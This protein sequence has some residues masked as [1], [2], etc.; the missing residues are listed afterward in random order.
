MAGTYLSI[1]DGFGGMRIKNGELYFTPF[2]PPQWNRY[3]FIVKFRGKLIK[4]EVTKEKTIIY[5]QHNEKINIIVHGVDYSIN[6]N[7]SLEIR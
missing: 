5:N 3:S 6:A 4:I 7:D 2:I 1:V